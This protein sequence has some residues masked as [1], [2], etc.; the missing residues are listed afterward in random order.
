MKPSPTIFNINLLLWSLYNLVPR[1]LKCISGQ[2]IP[3]DLPSVSREAIFQLSFPW[4]HA[5]GFTPPPLS[6]EIRNLTALPS[7]SSRKTAARSLRQALPHRP[8]PELQKYG[9]GGPVIHPQVWEHKGLRWLRISAMP[10]VELLLVWTTSQKLW[11]VSAVKAS[12][13]H[14]TP[15]QLSPAEHSHIGWAAGFYFT[16]TPVRRN[17]G[18]SCNYWGHEEHSG[19]MHYLLTGFKCYYV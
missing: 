4:K 18:S 17:H 8:N 2:Q 11:E 3:P 16:F 5:T 7:S 14:K 1:D 19:S 10:S 6:A 15:A 13:K 12:L 9:D